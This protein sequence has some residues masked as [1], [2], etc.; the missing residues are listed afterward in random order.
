[1]IGKPVFPPVE[2]KRPQGKARPPRRVAPVVYKPLTPKAEKQEV[3]LSGP[4]ADAAV[5]GGG[6]YLVLLLAANKK[7]AVFD[8]TQGKVV[9]ELPVSDD[10]VHFAAGADKLVVLY[11]NPRLVQIWSLKTFERERSGPLP[12]SLTRDDIHQVCM[13][14]ASPGPLFVYLPREKRTL[15]LDLDDLTTTEVRWTHWS[16]TN[17]YGPLHMRA[18]PDASTL[19]GWSGGWAGM[20]MATFEDGRQTGVRDKFEFS[21]GAF[22]LPSADSRFIFTPWAIVRRADLTA[23]KAPGVT[24]HYLVPAHEPG[25]FIAL[26]GPDLPN[27]PYEKGPAIAL[28]AVREA[29]FFNED[30][31]ELFTRAD[32]DE[33][34]AGCHIHWEK[35]VHYYPRAG[36]LITLANKDHLRLRRVDLVEQLQRS[37][38]NYLVVLSQPPPGKAGADHAYRLDVRARKGGVRVRLENG[39]EGLRVTPEGQVSWRI[40]AAFGAAEAEVLVSIRDA[41]EQEV[42]HTFRIPV[43]KP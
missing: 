13:G 32:L 4:V 26:R 27:S 17:A 18:S 33:L 38:K 43:A 6:R 37:G 22:A 16:P 8:V 41:T 21:M 9:R 39:P 3:A 12:A 15:A 35:A 11:P 29:S 1:M 25:Y 34:R 20:A 36:L 42:L 31:K 2:P 40:P 30:R 19:L 7:L 28:P 5:G 23:A 24:G 10:V 14:S